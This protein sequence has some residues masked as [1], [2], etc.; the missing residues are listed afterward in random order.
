MPSGQDHRRRVSGGGSRYRY[1]PWPCGQPCLYQRAQS[2]CLDIFGKGE[3]AVP[4]IN[5]NQPIEP[6]GLHRS[7]HGLG[8]A[9]T[10]CGLAA[11]TAPSFCAT[12]A[13]SSNRAAF[14]AALCFLPSAIAARTLSRAWGLAATSFAAAASMLASLALE[15]ARSVW[16]SVSTRSVASVAPCFAAAKAGRAGPS[17]PPPRPAAG[18]PR[19]RRAGAGGVVQTPGHSAQG[20]SGPHVQDRFPASL[21]RSAY[22]VRSGS[23]LPRL[24]WSPPPGGGRDLITIQKAC[25]CCAAAVLGGPRRRVWCRVGIG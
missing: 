9:W 14:M 13:A 4:R 17:S 25:W 22:L 10:G 23:A 5:D 16:A 3:A 2:N 19:D 15:S 12:A 18:R 6:Q 24:G 8:R 7:A 21:S 11:A 1:P 20:Y